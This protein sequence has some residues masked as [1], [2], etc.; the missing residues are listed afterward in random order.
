MEVTRQVTGYRRTDG[1]TGEVLGHEELDLPAT[2]LVTRGVRLH[3]RPRAVLARAG[4]DPAAGPGTLHAVEHAAI[5]M[6]PLFTICDRWDVG[7]CRP[8]SRPTPASRPIV[9]Y[10]GYEGGA[11]IAELGYQAADRHLAA[12]LEAVEGCGCPAGCPSCVQSP[13]CGNFNE[14]L[15]K[16]GAIRLLRE[17][18]GSGG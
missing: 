17:V 1:R 14:P 4:I 9:V 16:A 10:D 6:L 5:G 18:L 12:T 13:K 3:G 7:G 8:W 2:H 15:D 11:G